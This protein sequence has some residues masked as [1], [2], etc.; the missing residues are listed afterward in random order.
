MYGTK[1]NQKGPSA[2]ERNAESKKN[3]QK[4]IDAQKKA[5]ELTRAAAEAGDP[6]KRQRLLN[7]ALE[8]EIASESYGKTAKFIQSGTFQGLA[9]GTGIGV[10]TGA[11]LGTLS[12]ALVGGTTSMIIGGLG[13]AIGGGVGALHGSFV[14]MGDVAG[15]VTK[16]AGAGP[17]WEATDEQK[18]TLEKMIG[19]VK[20]TE[21][22]SEDELMALMKGGGGAG[23]EKKGAE[24]GHSE[25]KGDADKNAGEPQTSWADTAASY[26]PSMS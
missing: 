20:A 5:K 17:S 22:P 7:E 21:R 14:K 4:S 10:G 1:D 6:E 25:S 16:L 23:S 3:A 24:G 18:A 2:E 12:G 13:G 8:Q 19:Q 9:A 26:L 11:G 15:G